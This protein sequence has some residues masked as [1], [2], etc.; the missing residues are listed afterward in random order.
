M[1]DDMQKLLVW[2]REIHRQT[3]LILEA[4]GAVPFEQVNW[5][6]WDEREK[7]LAML[8]ECI[9]NG[10]YHVDPFKMDRD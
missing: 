10:Y 2:I 1:T 4:L 5:E 3:K 6:K 7:I 8:I 9:E